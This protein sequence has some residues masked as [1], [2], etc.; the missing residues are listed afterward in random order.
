MRKRYQ[1]ETPVTVTMFEILESNEYDILESTDKDLK[2]RIDALA[3]DLH[4]DW[5]V[6]KENDKPICYVSRTY[7]QGRVIDNDDEMDVSMAATKFLN[8]ISKMELPK[9]NEDAEEEQSNEAISESQ[10]DVEFVKKLLKDIPKEI[11]KEDFTGI[12][13]AD[14]LVSKEGIPFYYHDGRIGMSLLREM[15]ELYLEAHHEFKENK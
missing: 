12:V 14:L 5:Y 7:A 11:P 10:K 13:A 1:S 9:K 15:C 8:A 6:D 3:K 4:I 2:K